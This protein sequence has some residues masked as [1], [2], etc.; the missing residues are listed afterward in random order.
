[1]KRTSF[2]LYH[3]GTRILWQGLWE[4]GV[5]GSAIRGLDLDR[6]TA[7]FSAIGTPSSHKELQTGFVGS[8]SQAAGSLATFEPSCICSSVGANYP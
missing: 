7:S 6:E 8:T 5:V 4:P 2:R 3:L 1:M